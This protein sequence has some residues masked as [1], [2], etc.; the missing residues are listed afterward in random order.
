MTAITQQPTNPNF[1]N[2]SNF[3]FSL[4]R[5]PHLSFFAQS[6]DIPGITLPV[7]YQANPF[8]TISRPGQKVGFE[9]FS[10]TFKVDE[11][12]GNYLEVFNWIIALGFPNS[13]DQYTALVG[14]KGKQT[15]QVGRDGVFSDGSLVILSSAHNPMFEITFADM[16]PIGLTPLT[17]DEKATS[18][19]ILD[20]TA[21]FA[22]ERFYINKI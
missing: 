11:D 19:E 21:T 18:V 14:P 17:F 4:K 13:P 2:G 12:L 5:A 7:S 6:T 16:F 20:C 3:R 1:L 9:E 8:G 15:P 22:Y 10:I